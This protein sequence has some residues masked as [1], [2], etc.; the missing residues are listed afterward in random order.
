MLLP[1]SNIGLTFENSS[2]K[3]IYHVNRK[4]KENHEQANDFFKPLIKFNSHAWEKFLTIRN[5]REPPSSG[6]NVRKQNKTKP[7][8]ID[9]A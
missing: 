7:Y 4:K 5:G 9:H 2:V 3:A 1:E 6:G 8:S